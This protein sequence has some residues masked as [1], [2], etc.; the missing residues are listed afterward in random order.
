MQNLCKDI[1][2]QR[3]CEVFGSVSRR[4]TYLYILKETSVAVLATN[5]QLILLFYFIKNQMGLTSLPSPQ[6]SH[7]TPS[8]K[9]FQNKIERQSLQVKHTT[10]LIICNPDYYI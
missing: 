5:Q 10:L 9:T 2:M 8:D 3:L 6:F 1:A 7:H 4:V